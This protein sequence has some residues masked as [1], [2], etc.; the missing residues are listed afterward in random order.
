MT[1]TY[2][3]LKRRE[4]I[5]LGF[6]YDN[7]IVEE[8]GQILE[9]ET[10]I[11]LLLQEP[12]NNESRLKRVILIGDNNQLPPVVQ[13]NAYR[14]YGN[15]DQSLFTRFIRTQIP[16][17]NLDYQGRS[18][19]TIVDLYRWRYNIHDLQHV[20]HKHENGLYYTANAGLLYEYQFINVPDH[21]GRGEICPSP[22]YYQNLA[23]AEYVVAMYMYMCLNGYNPEKI[24]ILTT[25]R[26]QKQLIKDIIKQKCEWNP[27][28]KT[29]L[30]I[31]TVDKYQ[32]QQNDY[33]L[34]SLVRTKNIG[35]LR[36]IR[37][38]VVALSRAKL[39]LYIFG[40]WDLYKDCFE[41]KKSFN[42]LN[43]KPK[44]LCIVINESFPTERVFK[45]YNIPNIKIE[46]FKHLYRI[47]QELLKFKLIHK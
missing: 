37:R 29:P 6:E 39:G 41:L 4:L 7:I 46:D 11:P 44:D 17:I 36:D 9:I 38:L 22:F 27:F 10:F 42:L 18:R 16:T 25:Y 45:E 26:G 8:A 35:H 13:N 5:K 30:K 31:T 43:Q 21:E 2:A 28:F 19:P 40:R 20:L 1:C 14:L 32:G 24:S 15:M 23:E 12:K 3:A 33:I 34:L 47:D